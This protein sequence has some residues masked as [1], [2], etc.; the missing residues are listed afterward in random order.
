MP[1]VAHAV[2]SDPGGGTGGGGT[3]GTTSPATKRIIRLPFV[4]IEIKNVK[5]DHKPPTIKVVPFPGLHRPA[6]TQ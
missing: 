3:G 4:K 6:P 5:G 2:E 1:G